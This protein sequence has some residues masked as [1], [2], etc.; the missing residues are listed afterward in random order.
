MSN[1]SDNKQDKWTEL[2]ESLQ[3]LLAGYADNELDEQDTLII[4]AHLSGC[5]SC[6]ND[7]ARQKLLSERLEVI[8]AQKITS[9][10]QQRIDNIRLEESSDIGDHK[11]ISL[12][13]TFISFKTWL[14]DMSA[15]PIF[16]ASGWAFAIVLAVVISLPSVW[17]IQGNRIPMID[18]AVAEYHKMNSMVFP[19]V[20]KNTDIKAP[21]NF[22]EGRTLATWATNIAGEPAQAFAV[23]SGRNIIFQYKINETVLFRNPEVRQAIADFGNY[24]QRSNKVDVLALPL[25]DSG[26]LVVGPAESLPEIKKIEF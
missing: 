9:S 23:R 16:A 3:D 21:V 7:L 1:Q 11:G 2:H 17:Q 22:P 6:R 14:K 25:T 26:V 5:D 10:L 15:Q 4:E 12:D 20:N 19:A 13:K 18:D 8:P 24:K